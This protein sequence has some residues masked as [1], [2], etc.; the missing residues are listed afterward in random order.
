MLTPRVYKQVY[1][2]CN[3]SRLKRALKNIRKEQK[4]AMVRWLYFSGLSC[5]LN[6]TVLF[7][8]SDAFV[9]WYAFI[10]LFFIFYF[11]F[12]KDQLVGPMP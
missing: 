11:H 4:K 1:D 6:I 9:N 10:F 12:K 5:K 2:Y 7:M 3:D 8:F